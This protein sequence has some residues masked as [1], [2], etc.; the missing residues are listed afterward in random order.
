MNIQYCLQL[1][2]QNRLNSKRI[3][4]TSVEKFSEKAEMRC[5]SDAFRAIEF[6]S[7]VFHQY[8]QSH[9]YQK[10]LKMSSNK[11]GGCKWNDGYS[12]SYPGFTAAKSGKKDHCRCVPC[13]KDLSIYHKGKK[14]I[15][16]HMNTNEHKSN[17]TKIAG[18]KPLPNLFNGK[19]ISRTFLF[20]GVPHLILFIF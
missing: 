14:D 1:G 3:W 2:K 5:D 19:L 16:K 15:E 8:D 12:K 17:C 7:V 10:S 11:S 4:H 13:N 6:Q 20:F 9:P 18:T